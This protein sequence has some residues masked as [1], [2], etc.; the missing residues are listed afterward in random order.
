MKKRKGQFCTALGMAMLVFLLAACGGGVKNAGDVN[1]PAGKAPEGQ[2]QV[3]NAPKENKTPV[4]IVFYSDSGG[5]VE[6]FNNLYGE[7]LKKKFPHYNVT[8]FMKQKGSTLRELLTAGQPIDI[9][10]DSIGMFSGSVI[11]S[12]LSYD[13]SDLIKEAG[14]DL[15]RLEPTMLDAMRALSKG[16]LYGLP[17]R[18]ATML[19]YYNKDIF[20]KFGVDYPVDGMTWEQTIELGNRLTRSD[21]GKHYIGFSISEGHY[22]RMNPFSLP[23]VDTKTQ[24]A[25][26]NSHEKWKTFFQTILVAPT[27]SAAYREYL[28]EKKLSKMPST[29]EFSKTQDLAMLGWLSGAEFPGMNVNVVAMPTFSELPGVGTQAYP[30]YYSVTSISKH[31]KEAMEIIAYLVS[32]E[33]QMILSK[34]GILPA[35]QTDAIKNA[36]G[37]ESNIKNLNTKAFFYNKLAPISEKLVY[38]SQVETEYRKDV[39][40]LITGQIDLNTFLRNAEERAAK[41]LAELGK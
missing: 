28:A 6:E 29:N 34:R 35:V 37:S 10:Y 9:V 23:Y 22:M 40:K 5:S 25:T 3:E 13:M 33:F 12:G 18:Y 36:F 27:Q 26:I 24:K 38:D 8:Y 11:D 1:P 14:V 39:G 16:G 31:K 32:D 19:L 30:T 21:G 2:G 17:V 20:D 15:N 7:A 41:L 4:D